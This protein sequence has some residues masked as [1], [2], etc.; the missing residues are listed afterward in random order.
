MFKNRKNNPSLDST[1]Q[2]WLYYWIKAIHALL[3]KKKQLKFEFITQS[4]Y[5]SSCL[6]NLK[7][8]LDQPLSYNFRYEKH[9]VQLS[10]FSF[11]FHI[12]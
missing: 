6:G 7:A 10:H 11:N 4:T 12:L 3:R 1:V 9:E 2:Y 8:A 5:I